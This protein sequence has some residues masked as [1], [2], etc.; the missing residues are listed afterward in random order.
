[1]LI[2]HSLVAYPFVL[3]SVRSAARSMDKQLAE[4][5]AVLGAPPRRAWQHVQ[6][7]VLSRAMA[8]GALLAFVI[9]LGELG[10]TLLLREPG[11]TTMPIAIYEAIGQPGADSLGRALAL[12][13]ILM[14]VTVVAFSS[15]SGSG[16]GT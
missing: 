6:L 5:A 1:M 11:F 3:R 12:S 7:P 15:S 10:A 13:T 16:T 14:G 2:A 9:S 4:A 8:V